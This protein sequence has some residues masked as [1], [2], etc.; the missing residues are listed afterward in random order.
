MIVSVHEACHA[1]HRLFTNSPVFSA[2]IDRDGGGRVR[3][4]AGDTR[5]PLTGWE[6]LPAKVST[7]DETKREWVSLLTGLAVAK[8]GQRKYSGSDRYDWN[9]SHDYEI[10]SRVLT[11]ISSSLAE[12]RELLDEVEDRAARFVNAHWSPI[13]RLA[14]VL[15]ARGWVGEQEIKSALSR[16][17]SVKLNAAGADLAFDLVSAGKINWGGFA[18]DSPDDDDL[19]DE[20]DEGSKYHLGVD[21]DAETVGAGK[22]FYPFTKSGN[23]VYVAALLD[24]EKQGGVVGEFAAQLLDKISKMKAQAK[25]NTPK[26][27][28]DSD[29]LRWRTDGY[30][31]NPFIR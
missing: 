30:L 19:L 18:W 13:L 25:A 21:E 7:D 4:S 14:N 31:I 28:R 22:F 2:E 16:A 29:G 10:I 15:C 17:S 20:E 12:K 8:F 24:A 11:A 3:T 27:A 6:P 1:A 9:C 5:P 26:R 23:E